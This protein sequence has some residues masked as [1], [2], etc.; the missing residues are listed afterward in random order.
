VAIDGAA[1]LVL[2]GEPGEEDAPAVRDVVDAI[3]ASDR[4]VVW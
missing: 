2:D 3:L 1:R 4:V